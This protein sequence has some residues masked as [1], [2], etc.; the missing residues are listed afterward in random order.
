MFRMSALISSA[1]ACHCWRSFSRPDSASNSPVQ[2]TQHITFDDVAL[3]KLAAHLPDSPV[4]LTPMLDGLFHRRFSTGHRFSGTAR[5]LCVQEKRVQDGT[6]M[7]CCWLQ[8]ADAHRRA[9]S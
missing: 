2:G 8:A 5:G 1:S 3:K 9:R 4:G 7:P 6:Q